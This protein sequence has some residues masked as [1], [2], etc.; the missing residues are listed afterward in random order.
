MRLSTAQIKSNFHWNNT[1]NKVSNV[2]VY[3]N[4]A[5]LNNKLLIIV[6]IVAKC[7]QVQVII[8]NIVAN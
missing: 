2:K 7:K 5:R 1:Q 4:K 8:M 6:M 3:A